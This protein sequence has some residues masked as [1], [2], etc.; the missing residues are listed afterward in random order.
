M[1]LSLED[2]PVF[3]SVPFPG[4]IFLCRTYDY[5][6]PYLYLLSYCLSPQACESRHRLFC[7]LSH[8]SPRLTPAMA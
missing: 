4:L 7:S 8:P 5:L 2:S 3:F 1:T 6:T